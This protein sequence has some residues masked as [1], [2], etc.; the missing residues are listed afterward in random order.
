MYYDASTTRNDFIVG[1]TSDIK[2]TLT[3]I[4][5]NGQNY[6]VFRLIMCSLSEMWVAVV[7]HMISLKH[8]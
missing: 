7:E 4:N 2:K 3:L 5:K 1:L 6:D 8:K